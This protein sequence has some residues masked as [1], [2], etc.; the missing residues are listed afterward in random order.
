MNTISNDHLD[1]YR[2][3]AQQLAQQIQNDPTFRMAVE[4]DPV[5][6]LGTAGLPEALIPLFL[7]ETEVSGDVSGYM[8]ELEHRCFVT[9]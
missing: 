2:T 8:D 3:L 9:N 7:R 1:A 6:A 4:N 5:T